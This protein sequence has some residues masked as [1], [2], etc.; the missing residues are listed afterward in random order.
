VGVGH[1]F[2][3]IVDPFIRLRFRSVSWSRQSDLGPL[4]DESSRVT[5]Y[6]A[7]ISSRAGEAEEGLANENES[8]STTELSNAL[9]DYDSQSD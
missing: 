8:S 5:S 7:K 2:P 3:N 1:A 9:N 6:A 4:G